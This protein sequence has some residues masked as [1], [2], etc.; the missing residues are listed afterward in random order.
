LPGGGGALAGGGYP[1]YGKGYPTYIKKVM[2]I[3]EMYVALPTVKYPAVGAT[4]EKHGTHSYYVARAKEVVEM[5]LTWDEA[6]ARKPAGIDTRLWRQLLHQ[7]QGVEMTSPEK[8]FVVTPF[9]FKE[10]TVVTER[11]RLKGGAKQTP[12]GTFSPT[13]MKPVVNKKMA[14]AQARKLYGHL[15]YENQPE[16]E[17]LAESVGM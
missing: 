15:G 7:E 2:E 11:V 16:I 14:K 1:A 13:T 4:I 12:I 5:D 8:E 17:A 3:P 6:M 10:V 9:G